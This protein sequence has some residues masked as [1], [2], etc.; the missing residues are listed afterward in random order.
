MPVDAARQDAAPRTER[1]RAPRRLT[2]GTVVSA[3]MAK[4]ISVQVSRKV[5]HPKYGKFV[6]RHEVYKAHDEEGKAKAGDLVEIAFARRLSKTKFWRLVRV[7]T[8]AR[9]VA[10]RGEEEIASLPG[11][12]KA[13]PAAAP[14]KSSSSAKASE[15]TDAKETS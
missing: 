4:T 2:T 6:T 7:V 1:P 13:A 8:A 11:T 10:V 12:A 3:K 14:A 5:R 15:A 9:V